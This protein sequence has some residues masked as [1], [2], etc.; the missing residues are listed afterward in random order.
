MSVKC[1]CLFSGVKHD[2]YM[3][4]SSGH[5]MSIDHCVMLTGHKRAT[6]SGEYVVSRGCNNLSPVICQNVSRITSSKYL[7]RKQNFSRYC[8]NANIILLFCDNAATHSKIKEKN[9][10]ALQYYNLQA[11]PSVNL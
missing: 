5:C 11:I 2:S 10:S 9:I 4:A 1:I 6:S 7:T 3:V 8:T